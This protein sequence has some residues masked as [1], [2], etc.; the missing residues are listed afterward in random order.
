MIKYKYTKEILEPI[1]KE[2]LSFAQVIRKLGIKWSGGQQQNIKRRISSY[3]IDISHFLGQRANCGTN[4]KG[5][6]KE[7]QDILILMPDG[8]SR[9]EAYKL[10]RALIEC[11]V[12]YEC[13]SCKNNGTWCDKVLRLQVNHKNKNW[14]DNRSENLE[15]L[16]PN[17]HSQTASWGNDRG[18]TNLTTRPWR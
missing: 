12:V 8:S 16:C 15:F 10:R 11:G 1:V 9:Q 6:K 2:S 4:H 17:C 18:G 5:S 14:L 13:S 7:W 3:H